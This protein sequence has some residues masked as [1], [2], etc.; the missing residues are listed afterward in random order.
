MTR[1]D[2]HM[3]PSPCPFCG[4]L[5]DRST[6]LTD[7]GEPPDAKDSVTICT[8]CA[9]I[10]CFNDDLTLRRPRPGELTAI[11]EQGDGT[12][13]RLREAQWAVRMSDR[14]RLH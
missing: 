5:C 3:P 2:Y 13:E 8:C 14:R 7:A 1:R 11:K 4:Y 12:Y 10:L 9:S 6:E